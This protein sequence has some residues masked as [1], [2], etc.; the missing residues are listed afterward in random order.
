MLKNVI[1]RFSILKNIDFQISKT[2]ANWIIGILIF[3][4]VVLIVWNAN[5]RFGDD[6][7]FLFTTA[8]GKLKRKTI[9]INHKTLFQIR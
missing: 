3:A 2:V 6:I 7:Q 4:G 9:Q 1:N 5:W 8:S